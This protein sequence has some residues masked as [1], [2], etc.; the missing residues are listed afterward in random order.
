M[1]PAILV[2]RND[3]GSTLR[4]ALVFL[5][6][7]LFCATCGWMLA[8]SFAPLASDALREDSAGPAMRHPVGLE[9]PTGSFHTRP[10]L[11]PFLLLVWSAMTRTAQNILRM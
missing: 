6:S 2:A 5:S 4:A 3:L 8:A 7:V 9:Q 1:I 11:V 10:S